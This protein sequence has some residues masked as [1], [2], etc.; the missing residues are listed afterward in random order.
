MGKKPDHPA[1]T[2]TENKPKQKKP[3]RFKACSGVGKII[4]HPHP[5]KEEEKQRRS[6]NLF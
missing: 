3:T 5:Q 4:V 2:P 6:R 1:Q